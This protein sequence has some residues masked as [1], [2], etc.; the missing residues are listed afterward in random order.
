[1]AAKE[2]KSPL[3]DTRGTPTGS[4]DSSEETDNADTEKAHQHPLRN[5]QLDQHLISNGSA[6]P[7]SG[8]E[9]LPG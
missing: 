3:V 7:G 9:P 1:M 6:M 5:C 2:Q 8:H 4:K